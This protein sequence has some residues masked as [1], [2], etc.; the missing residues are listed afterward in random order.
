MLVSER[1]PLTQ[2]LELAAELTT[3]LLIVEF[4]APQ[5]SMFRLL[6]RGRGQ[7]HESLTAAV[8]EATAQQFFEIEC[9][10]RVGES[11]RWMYLMRKKEAARSA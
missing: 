5:D 9:S 3:N 10:R 6:T 2:T 8:F 11:D 4:V 1:I 7:L